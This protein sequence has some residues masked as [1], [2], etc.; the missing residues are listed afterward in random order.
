MG[1]RSGGG[2]SKGPF[3][4]K[5]G[6]AYNILTQSSAASSEQLVLKTC[7]GYGATNTMI[8]RWT[9]I[10]TDTSGSSFTYAD[11]ADDGMTV[12]VNTAG[13]YLVSYCD[14]FDTAA[15]FGITVNSSDLTTS[16]LLLTAAKVSVMSATPLANYIQNVSVPLI[17]SAADVV[18]TH[19]DSNSSGTRTLGESFHMVRIY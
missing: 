3:I 16:I 15:N 2:G 8:R 10:E 19:A 6:E 12:T 11:S 4:F 18:R 13:L 14:Q 5:N 9:T 1:R 7:N 17:L